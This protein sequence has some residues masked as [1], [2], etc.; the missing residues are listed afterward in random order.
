[1]QIT[2]IAFYPN[3][4]GVAVSCISAE[5]GVFK[6][7]IY[8]L[9]F[10]ITQEDKIAKSDFYDTMIL[11]MDYKSNGQL[12]MIGD[13]LV[14]VT[15]NNGEVSAQYPFDRTLQKFSNDPSGNAVLLLDSYGNNSSGTLVALDTGC[16]V[17]GS[18]EIAEAAVNLSCSNSRAALLSDQK[19]QLYDLRLNI[20]D[21]IAVRSDSN[22]LSLTGSK[23][24][25]L[26]LSDISQYDAK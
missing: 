23:L 17:V 22:D 1:M 6:S 19:V 14:A 5:N 16:N 26:G 11:S 4:N 3:G 20:V 15:N 18:V 2:G 24:Y 13:N 8:Y 21:E 10:S 9:D 25:V 12:M 7:R